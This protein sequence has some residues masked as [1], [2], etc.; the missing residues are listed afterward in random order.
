MFCFPKRKSK[1]KE[2]I[3]DY[4]IC[5]DEKKE[6][7]LKYN[8]SSPKKAAIHFI[9]EIIKCECIES[10]N[11]TDFCVIE[12]NSSKLTKYQVLGYKPSIILVK[13]E[14]N[15]TKNEIETMIILLK[16]KYNF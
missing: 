13:V 1:I 3:I 14:H 4:N 15:F 7:I 9:N 2:Y 6:K 8:A 16:I 10:S 12:T 5:K 11:V